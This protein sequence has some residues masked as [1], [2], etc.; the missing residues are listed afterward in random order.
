[1]QNPL[2]KLLPQI[3]QVKQIL[4]SVQNPNAM[5]NQILQSNPQVSQIIN[6]YGS[7]DGAINAICQQ[8]GINPQEFMDAL[9]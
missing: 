8:Q 5:L 6:Q 7:I 3:K 1:M 2:A 9:K 4:G